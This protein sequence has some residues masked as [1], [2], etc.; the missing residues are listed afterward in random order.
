[1]YLNQQLRPEKIP[2][3]QRQCNEALESQLPEWLWD[4]P[5]ELACDLH[6][7]PYYGTYDAEAPDNW[8]R[9]GEA[10]DGTTRFYCCATV[11]VIHRSM[12]MTLAVEF[13]KPGMSIV[14]VLKHLLERVKV[15]G[16]TYKSLFLDKGFCSIPI[17]TALLNQH[18]PVLMAAP[19]KGKKGGTRA[20]CQG[21]R[22]YY[23]QHTFRSQ[24]HGSLTVT[25]AVVR[26]FAKRRHGPPRAQWLVYVVL[27]MPN[28]PIRAVRK[29]YRRR[30]GIESSYRM[31]EKNRPRTT[32]HNA[33]LRF[34]FM[35][36][37][38]IILNIWIALQWTFLRIRGPGPR[39]VA[40][41][42][43]RQDRMLRFLSRAVEMIYSVVSMVDP[44]NVRP[45]LSIL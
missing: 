4:H 10:R 20:L 32:S 19:L 35:G 39:R 13:V 1:M 41:Q 15:L 12:R 6:E 30:F 44:P 34:L 25:V 3:L 27:N 28:L 7:E 40:N 9:G 36:L 17:M 38:L 45:V 22:S 16:I 24:T 31:M 42:H 33:A 37:A 29:T 21:Q 43:L 26:T 8:V 5:Q 23:T 11:Y 18:V 14:E 2:E